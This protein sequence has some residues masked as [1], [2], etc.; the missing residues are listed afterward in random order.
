[1]KNKNKK[2]NYKLSGFVWKIT[3]HSNKNKEQNNFFEAM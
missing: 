1:M 3:H 2:E